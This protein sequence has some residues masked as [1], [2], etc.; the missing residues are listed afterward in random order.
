VSR[1][2]G[3]VGPCGNL[4]AYFIRSPAFVKFFITF[5]LVIACLL[6]ARFG[7][8]V[9]VRERSCS[10]AAHQIDSWLDRGP[11]APG[12]QDARRSRVL[13]MNEY[14][15][16]SAR[17]A[18]FLADSH[19]RD[20][21]RPGEA[22][23]R[24]RFIDF[25]SGVPSG[26]AV[27]FSATSFDFLFRVRVGRSQAVLRHSSR[28]ARLLAARAEVHFLGGNTTIGSGASFGGDR[29]V[30]Q[31]DDVFIKCQGRKI[32]CTHGDLFLTGDIATG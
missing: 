25:L 8:R 21:G 20:R 31:G 9:P 13:R 17:E 30:P 16:I 5:G 29:L 26:T 7:P 4:S 15:D 28:A 19:F 2:R 32:W 11:S 12:V 6:Y 23:R 24:R 14:V 22:D 1:L 18:L 27:F 3:D 10:P